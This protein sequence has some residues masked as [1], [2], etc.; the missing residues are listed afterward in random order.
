MDIYRQLIGGHH[1]IHWY[2]KLDLM[3][4]VPSKTKKL[5]EIS[6]GDCL[7]EAWI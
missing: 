2:M 5:I 1:A 3:V 6:Q 4:E 7:D